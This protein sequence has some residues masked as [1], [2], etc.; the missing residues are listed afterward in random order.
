MFICGSV[1]MQSFLREYASPWSQFTSNDYRDD[2]DMSFLQAV[3]ALKNSLATI[4]APNYLPSLSVVFYYLFGQ[5][6]N[7]I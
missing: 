2:V 6:V 5:E 7:I 4:K 1:H 3:I